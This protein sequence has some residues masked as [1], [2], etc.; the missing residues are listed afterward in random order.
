MKAAGAEAGIIESLDF[1]LNG[2]ACCCFGARQSCL[3]TMTLAAEG[4]LRMT[5]LKLAASCFLGFAS[6]A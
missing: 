1:L 6:A 3:S 4:C 5:R 2:A